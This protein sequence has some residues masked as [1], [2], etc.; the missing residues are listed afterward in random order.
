MTEAVVQMHNELNK[1]DSDKIDALQ[2]RIKQLEAETQNGTQATSSQGPTEPKSKSDASQ[3]SPQKRSAPLPEISPH[4]K[5]QK[6]KA[7]D[8]FDPTSNPNNRPLANSAPKSGAKADVD[9]WLSQ[10]KKSL[11]P[12]EA[13]K[14]TAYIDS[15]Q[16]AYADIKP[17]GPNLKCLAA[18]RAYQLT[19]S[20]RT[21]LDQ[22]H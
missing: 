5:R 21:T 1:S 22:L 19:W 7:T 20:Q 14:R 3:S 8:A 11:D 16:K 13:E 9:R 4:S 12:P 6:L 10:I 18:H 17:N 2:A 15:V